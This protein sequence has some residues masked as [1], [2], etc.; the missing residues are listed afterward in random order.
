[1]KEDKTNALQRLDG[2]AA[3]AGER[4][5]A[6]GGGVWRRAVGGDLQFGTMNSGGRCR[7]ATVLRR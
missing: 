1:M 5:G 2:S 7:M 6:R 3:A 4:G